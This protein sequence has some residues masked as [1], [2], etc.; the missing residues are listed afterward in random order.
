MKH[1]VKHVKPYWY[2]LLGSIV[3]IALQA[4]L[5]L[6]MPNVMSQIVNVGIQEYSGKIAA[7][8]GAAAEAL[9]AE[10]RAYIL[11]TGAKMMGI[12]LLTSA[13]SLRVAFC[14]ARMGTGLARDLRKTVFTKIESFSN[15]EFDR[16]STASL[17]TRSTNDVQQI[18]MLLTMGVR[19]IVFAP[20]MGIGGVIMAMRKAPSMAWINALSVLLVACLMISIFSVTVKRFNRMQELVDRL[21]LVARESLSGLMVVRAFSTQKYEEERFNKANTDHMENN[22][23]V[24]RVMSFMGPTM[25]LIQSLVPVRIIWVGAPKIARSSLLVGDMM[26][27]I[28]YSGNIM[29]A[30]MMISGI[31]I[32]FPRAMVSVRRVSEV[33]ETKNVITDRPDAVV[34]E[35]G[36]C[37]ITFEDVSFTY[38]DS[39]GESLSDISFTAHPGKVTAIIG[40]TGSGKTTLVNLIMR[41]YD[42]T[43][44]SIKI[45][46]TDI[47]DITMHSLRE[48]VG[49]V[50]Q[51]SVLF[52]GTIKS[53]MLVAD[54]NATDDDIARACETAQANEFILARPE[55]YEYEIAQGG[56]NVSGGQRQRLAI[57]RAL[58]K[59]APIYIFDD[60]FSALDFKTDLKLRQ[61]LKENYADSTVLIVGQRVASIMD[62][63]Q[64]LVMDN[65]RIVGKGTH[66]ELMEGCEEYREIVFSQLSEEEVS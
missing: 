24:Q 23:F 52:S 3:L 32:M 57:A 4:Y 20:F 15:A 65:G 49:Y 12:A 22:L 66:Q 45:N 19:T 31:F 36:S 47:R 55:K 58:V 56:T 17:I 1:V 51:K 42:V 48:L 34:M 11:R 54:P 33:L 39:D 27:Y 16:F 38:P 2:F 40:S 63:D 10:Q 60:S 41:H 35:D 62:S 29:G 9:I 6:A 5:N 7:A 50:P 30:F 25:S 8:S 14:N 13:V 18:Q 37:E 21:N 59:K 61:A 44:G 26:A 46:G 28:Q 43:E 53:N 64:I